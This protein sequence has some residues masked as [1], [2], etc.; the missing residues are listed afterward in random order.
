M[1][2]GLRPWIPAALLLAVAIGV[3]TVAARDTTSQQPYS[4]LFDSTKAADD[5]QRFLYAIVQEADLPQEEMRTIVRRLRRP[6]TELPVLIFLARESKRPLAELVEMRKSGRDYLEMMNTLKVPLKRLFVDV[7][8]Q[9]PDQYKE[10]WVEWRMK[11]RPELSDDQIRDLAML[12]F[13]HQVT[14][15]PIDE[16]ARANTK[17]RTPEQFIAYHAQKKAK[18]A[19]RAAEEAKERAEA[20][21]AGKV[22]PATPPADEKA[23]AAKGPAGKASSGKARAPAARA[24]ARADRSR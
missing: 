5:E 17:G 8:G 24:P 3:M 16:L 18:D 20:V 6:N 4:Y 12:Q 1:Q 13:A 9:F 19:A 21:A 22:P 10:A 11:Y 15:T 14:G 23:A 7:T 2:Y